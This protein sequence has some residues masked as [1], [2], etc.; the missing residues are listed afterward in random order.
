M[1]RPLVIY[2]GGCRDGFCS[3]WVAH[4]ALSARMPDFHS[5]Y[6]GQPPPL[7]QAAGRDVYVIDFTYPLDQ[8]KQLAE[9][10]QPETMP[11]Q[12]VTLQRVEPCVTGSLNCTAAR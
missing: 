7:E 11:R 12:E 5:G 8:M 4:R 3:A 6:Y 10:A 9:V 2:H 1:T